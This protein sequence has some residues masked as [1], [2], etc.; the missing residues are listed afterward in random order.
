MLK[1][2]SIGLAGIPKVEFSR[3]PD[4]R[5]SNPQC[6]PIREEACGGAACRRT[7]DSDSRKSGQAPRCRV[8]H[9]EVVSQ[10]RGTEQGLPIGRKGHACSTRFLCPVNSISRSP[11]LQRKRQRI[12]AIVLP[13]DKQPL[14]SEERQSRYPALLLQFASESSHR[15]SRCRWSRHDPQ[16]PGTCRRRKT[17]PP[18]HGR[19]PELARRPDDLFGDP[20]SAASPR[21]RHSAISRESRTGGATTRNGKTMMSP[22]QNTADW[23]SHGLAEAGGQ[24]VVDPRVGG[25]SLLS[26]GGHR[27]WRRRGKAE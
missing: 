7:Q 12:T 19:L 25:M 2:A 22:A 26:A 9:S 6:G 5:S 16:W 1:T 15:R 4:R 11:V 18:R 8:P 13:R 27:I 24:L 14:P 21:R 3:R 17:P 10:G 23:T 20:A